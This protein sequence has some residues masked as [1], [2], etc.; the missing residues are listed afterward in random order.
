MPK[1]FKNFKG[2][3]CPQMSFIPFVLINFHAKKK[4]KTTKT[5]RNLLT[6]NMSI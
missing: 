1:F 2:I 4:K 5:F 3:T 6:F